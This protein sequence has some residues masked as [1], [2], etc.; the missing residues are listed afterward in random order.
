MV[1]LL[2]TAHCCLNPLGS[3]DALLARYFVLGALLLLSIYDAV[4]SFGMVV[5]VSS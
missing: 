2:K 5:R 3:I 1:A 4:D